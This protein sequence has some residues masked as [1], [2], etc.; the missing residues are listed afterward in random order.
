MIVIDPGHTYKLLVLD[1][2][3]EELLTFVKREGGG[4]PG[5]VG[6]YSGTNLQEVFRAAID[7]TKYLDN[8]I[9]H[10]V[11]KEI[12]HHLRSCIRLLEHRAAE[13]HG[14]DTDLF[15]YNSRAMEQ[16]ESMPACDQCG[17]IGCEGT[18]HF[19]H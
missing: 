10:P 12:I 17:H 6:H 2:T 13:R 18:C 3:N 9:S 8:Q 11:N 1:G 15:T 4:Y 5:N 19:H 7:R 14:R 16:V